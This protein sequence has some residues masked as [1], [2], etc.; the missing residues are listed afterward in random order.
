MRKKEVMTVALIG[1]PNSG[2]SAIFNAITGG[3]QKLGNWPGVTVEK[4]EGWF[5][6]ES[7]SLRIID[8]P[9]LYSLKAQS[10]DEQISSAFIAAGEADLYVNVLDASNLERNLYL[11]MQLLELQK[12]LMFVLNM[13]DIAQEHGI[14]I[15][16]E[17]LR[18]RLSARPEEEAAD[19]A[20][21]ISVSAIKKGAGKLL[22][23]ALANAAQERPKAGASIAY[24]DEL[25]KQLTSLGP[26]LQRTAAA[27]NLSGRV[28]ALKVL[29]GDPL[30]LS[31]A[32]ELNELFQNDIDNLKEGLRKALG[33]NPHTILAESR[34]AAA[35]GII[36]NIVT[37][38]KLPDDTLTEKIDRVVLNRFAGIP[39]FF[40]LMYGLFWSVI[41]LG[42]AFQD[43]FDIF[44]GALF[45]NAPALLLERAGAPAWLVTLLA[46][47]IG[48]GLQA[49]G[50]FVPIIFI[51]FLGLSLL[52]DSGYMA[53]AAFIMD[54]LMHKIGLPGKS[55]VPL[56][57]GFGCT[58]PAIM[59]ARSLDSKR[60]RVLTIFMAPLMSCGARLPVLALFGSAFFGYSAGNMVFSIYLI[61]IAIAIFSGMLINKT[62]LK[63]HASHFV[64]ELPPYHAPRLGL[65]LTHAWNRLKG[66]IFKAGKFLIIA[67]SIIGALN[68]IDL[69][70]RLVE[71]EADSVLAA[72]GKAV[73]P[74][75]GPFG[76]EEENW[77]ASVGLFTG[78]F[79]KEAII[80]TLSSI[81]GQNENLAS[82]E[83]AQTAEKEPENSTLAIIKTGFF[84]AIA[85]IPAGLA[86]AFTNPQ[87]ASS[88]SGESEETESM[89]FRNL[90][91]GFSQGK[92]Q[93]YAYLLFVLIYVPCLAAMGV[94]YRELGLF[95]WSLLMVYLTLLA[96]LAATLF[97]QI[98]LGHSIFWISISLGL[99]ALIII[100]FFILGKFHL[101]ETAL[102]KINGNSK[103]A[104]KKKDC[105]E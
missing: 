74:L 57:V 62:L 82:Q 8:L 88:D 65:V 34:Y 97:Y 11:T 21:L 60:D 86:D 100:V 32:F 33:H 75:F 84:E 90:N 23:T 9:G 54:K 68:T 91:R 38:K 36:A 105:C 17:A 103:K 44:G 41:K 104:N 19:A 15:N 64:M 47:G 16:L 49:I 94:A 46:N 37:R 95:F 101:P 39:F 89:L 40:L 70:G 3:N 45:V 58:V 24:P 59:G 35:R 28:A 81:Y 7:A 42:G 77:P 26:K 56:I 50:T 67:M 66:F 1:N 2:K 78:L 53:R 76:V 30:V 73:T 99:L 20:P 87:L 31:K 61:G 12:P 55:F 43:F 93:A 14:S 52:E 18:A 5:E 48:A 25:E 98:V 69:K 22:Q 71:N 83:E 85:S 92:W 79:A 6:T 29:D 10:E 51:M 4:K 13:E 96:W 72:A 27:L 102:Y 63:G 80:G